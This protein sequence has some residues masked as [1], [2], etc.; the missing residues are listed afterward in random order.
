MLFT[1]GFVDDVMFSWASGPESSTTSCFEEVCQMAVSAGHQTTTVF[2][3][4]YQDAALRAKS[5]IY[6]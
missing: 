4:V 3:R 6:D 5:A 2:D 1:S